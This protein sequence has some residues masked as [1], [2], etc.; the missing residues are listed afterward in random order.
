[1]T[2]VFV[3]FYRSVAS[4]HFCFKING[5]LATFWHL[6]YCGRGHN[7]RVSVAVPHS[8]KVGLSLPRRK[9][10]INICDLNEQAPQTLLRSHHSACLA[11]AWSPAHCLCA[12]GARIGPAAAR[13]LVGPRTRRQRLGGSKPAT[14]WSRHLSK[15]LHVYGT[16]VPV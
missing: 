5:L 16:H 10:R 13:G 14:H 4:K 11:P 6:D 9:P 8:R 15:S 1:M 12:P 3:C 2:G 7:R